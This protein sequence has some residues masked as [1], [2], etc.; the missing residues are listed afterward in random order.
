MKLLLSLIAGFQLLNPQIQEIPQS[1]IDKD[2]ERKKIEY[3]ISKKYGLDTLKNLN[4]EV[5]SE[6]TQ[7]GFSAIYSPWSDSLKLNY[8]G[9][10]RGCVKNYLNL[11]SL[12][13]RIINH[14]KTHYRVD[15]MQE[16]LGLK[17]EVENRYS[18]EILEEYLDKLNISER[19][20]GSS[21]FSFQN[22]VSTNHEDLT[23][24]ILDKIVNEGIAK[25]YEN[26][27]SK[28]VFT[29]WPMSIKDIKNSDEY[30]MQVYDA[31]WNLMRPIISTYGEKGIEYVLKNMPKYDDFSDLEAY[32]KK[33]LKELGEQ[34]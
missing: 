11:D 34:K 10:M 22:F 31:G 29:V 13:S 15:K 25:Y 9:I 23:N 7:L 5:L 14:E 2:S 19:E 8:Y 3:T 18:R 30:N 4:F 27:G 6:D 12:L 28:P 17:S 21:R 16:K 1:Q 26:P 33:I 24:T 32:Q 20:Q